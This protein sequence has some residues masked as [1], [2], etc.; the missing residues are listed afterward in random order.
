[1]AGSRGPNKTFEA[2]VQLTLALLAADLGCSI[3]D[4]SATTVNA[5]RDFGLRC[6]INPFSDEDTPTKR[7]DWV[8]DPPRAITPPPMPAQQ[9]IEPAQHLRRPPRQRISTPREWPPPSR[10]PANKPPPKKPR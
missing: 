10:P 9:P 4:F 1:V 8:V 5:V 3:D 6:M 7:T 2:D